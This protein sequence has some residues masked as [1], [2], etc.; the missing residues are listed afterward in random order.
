[1]GAAVRNSIL[2]LAILTCASSVYTQESIIRLQENST[3]NFGKGIVAG[4]QC[5]FL[6]H[7]VGEG[8][9]K[10]RMY[11]GFENSVEAEIGNE[12]VIRHVDYSMP[13]QYFGAVR[14]KILSASEDRASL[15]LELRSAFDWNMANFDQT[16]A[17]LI[18]VLIRPNGFDWT[19]Y[20]YRYT[21]TDVIMT[22]VFSTGV[23]L[24]GGIGFQEIQTRDSR[25]FGRFGDSSFVGYYFDGI[26]HITITFGFA[27]IA[28]PLAPGA[29]ALAELK[30]VPIIT[31][32]DDARGL[33]VNR[34]Y[35][36]SIGIRYQLNRFISLDGFAR[37]TILAAGQSESE[38]GISF[39][40]GISKQ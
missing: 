4:V 29:V 6:D 26:Q 1:L 34:G 40:A 23:L 33:I 12:G 7:F 22:K 11:M 31:P 20:H 39:N 9:T 3:A 19:S 27:G 13:N 35:C 32:S 38:L 28:I 18:A 17:R 30:S 16:K 5:K 37:S 8:Y 21:T 14:V 15:A 10:Y 36:G 2:A 24:N 25:V